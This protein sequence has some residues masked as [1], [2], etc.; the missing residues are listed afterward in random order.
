MP[1]LQRLGRSGLEPG[2]SPQAGMLS[3]RWRSGLLLVRCHRP[4]SGFVVLG[5]VAAV[6]HL[7]A[8]ITRQNQRFASIFP[9]ASNFR[10]II[11]CGA[12]EVKISAIQRPFTSCSN[13]QVEVHQT[14][15]SLD[16]QCEERCSVGQLS[17]GFST[18]SMTRVSTVRLA[19]TSLRPSSATAEKMVGPGSGAE[20]ESGC[21]VD[22]LR[23]AGC[24]MTKS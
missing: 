1:R 18:W 16:A 2:A 20:G 12:G 6:S 3:R 22:A 10:R 15:N 13:F 7:V 4:Q 19:G 23:F 5:D 8:N 21:G 11:S 17:D 24:C 14:S 9:W